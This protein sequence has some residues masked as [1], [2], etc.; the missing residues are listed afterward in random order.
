MDS[1]LELAKIVLDPDEDEL[2]LEECLTP[3]EECVRTEGVA[4]SFIITDTVHGLF[5]V[6]A[7]PF[8]LVA[9]GGVFLLP[10][11]SWPVAEAVIKQPRLQP[12]V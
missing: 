3:V 7:P 10:D 5:S 11:S 2:L 4:L 1:E 12:A 6:P 9:S 8:R